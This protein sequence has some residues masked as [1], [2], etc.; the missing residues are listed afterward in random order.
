MTLRNKQRERKRP[1]ARRKYIYIN[2]KKKRVS[3]SAFGGVISSPDLWCK[4][5]GN[6]KCAHYPVYHSK[7]EGGKGYLYSHRSPPPPPA[8]DT[9]ATPITSFTSHPHFSVSTLAP[10]HPMLKPHTAHILRS[11][12]S[13][14]TL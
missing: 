12:F 14:H 13:H 1:G 2:M 9:Q 8:P 3:E 4:R 5:G 6:K 10:S 11:F 7:G